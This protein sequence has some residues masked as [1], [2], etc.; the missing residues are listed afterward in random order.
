MPFQFNG[1][2]RDIDG[3]LA[4]ELRF[5]VFCVCVRV[6]VCVCVCVCVEPRF[7]KIVYEKKLGKIKKI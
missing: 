3:C 7:L 2:N 4:A 6:Y 5:L 1:K